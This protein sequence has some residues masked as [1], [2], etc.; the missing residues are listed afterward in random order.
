MAEHAKKLIPCA[1]EIT[2]LRL[3]HFVTAGLLSTSH[4]ISNAL[5]T[6]R[7]NGRQARQ[8]ASDESCRRS[9]AAKSSGAMNEGSV[10]ADHHLGVDSAQAVLT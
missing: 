8:R 2:G 7:S 6:S 5:M 10:V 1:A 9:V 3:I 4:S